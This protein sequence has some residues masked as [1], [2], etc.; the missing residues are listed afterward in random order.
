MEREIRSFSKNLRPVSVPLFV[1]R[2]SF[3]IFRCIRVEPRIYRI[4]HRI[5]WSI[6]R[7]NFE[8]E[9]EERLVS[10]E[11]GLTRICQR[12]RRSDNT[13]RLHNRSVNQRRDWPLPTSYPP[14]SQPVKSTRHRGKIRIVKQFPPKLRPINYLLFY[15]G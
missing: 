13:S 9:A 4:L 15:G 10:I 3:G 14:R 11:S 8:A 1:Y 7:V 5:G 12:A 6:I 2:A